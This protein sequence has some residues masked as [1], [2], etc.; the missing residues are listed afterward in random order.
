[1]EVDGAGPGGGEPFEGAEPDGAGSFS[2]ASDES[3]S[4]GTPLAE[5]PDSSMTGHSRRWII[6]A[7]VVGIGAVIAGLVVAES[8]SSGAVSAGKGTATI[9]WNP[10]PGAGGITNGSVGPPQPFTGTINGVAVSGVSTTLLTSNSLGSVTKPLSE[11]NIP[12]FRWKG[13]Y[14]G[15]PFDLREILFDDGS[16]FGVAGTYGDQSVKASISGPTMQNADDVHVPIDFQATIG[17]WKVSGT[18]SGPLGG[19]GK[20][21]ARATFT[22]AN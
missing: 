12:I 15:K 1:M 21:T 6:G 17:E 10:V 3:R 16:P 14:G 18:I 8:H 22:V 11:K 4:T 9:G 2:A 19:G 20:Q 7:G 13:T 5:G